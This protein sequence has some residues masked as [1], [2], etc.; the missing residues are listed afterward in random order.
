MG[1]IDYACCKQQQ[2]QQQ[3]QQQQ[4]QQ[5]HHK[6]IYSVVYACTMTSLYSTGQTE[7]LCCNSGIHQLLREVYITPTC[8]HQQHVH[9]TS[10]IQRTSH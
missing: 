2:H 6:H 3:Q 9:I 7:W 8:I 10:F 5:H 4:Q 1:S